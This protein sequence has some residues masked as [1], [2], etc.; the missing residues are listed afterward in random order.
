MKTAIRQVTHPLKKRSPQKNRCCPLKQGIIRQWMSARF[1][2][3]VQF[4]DVVKGWDWFHEHHSQHHLC[5][6]TLKTTSAPSAVWRHRVISHQAGVRWLKGLLTR[7]DSTGVTNTASITCTQTVGRIFCELTWLLW[8]EM[9]Q[10]SLR[11]SCWRLRWTPP[12]DL[13]TQRSGFST[14]VAPHRKCTRGSPGG[15]VGEQG[16]S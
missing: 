10:A 4:W 9:A 2:V 3:P 16:M 15:G 5:L 12:P 14:S 13:N 7:C 1:W 6:S 11:G 8:M